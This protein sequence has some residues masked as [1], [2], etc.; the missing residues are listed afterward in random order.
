MS[1]IEGL[2]H[3]GPDSGSGATELVYL[4]EAVITVAAVVALRP[5]R[6]VNSSSPAGMAVPAMMRGEGRQPEP[7]DSGGHARDRRRQFE[8]ER[9]LSDRPREL[10]LDDENDNDEESPGGKPE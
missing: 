5:L 3:V 1:W 10:N 2:L 4:V 8:E 9:G 6:S 7:P